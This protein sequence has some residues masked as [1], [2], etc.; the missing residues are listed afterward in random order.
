MKRKFAF[1]L[2][3]AI[4][5]LALLLGVCASGVS[6]FVEAESDANNATNEAI[7][8]DSIDSEKIDDLAAHPLI[9]VVICHDDLPQTQILRNLQNIARILLRVIG[10]KRQLGMDMIIVI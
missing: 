4:M 1:K 9:P 7:G 3:S 5:A 8:F 2:L 6:A 10:A